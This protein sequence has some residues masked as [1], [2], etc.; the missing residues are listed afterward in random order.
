MAEM[1]VSWVDAVRHASEHIEGLSRDSANH[2]PHGD[3]AA[4]EVAVK[5][6]AQPASAQIGVAL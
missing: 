5:A 4:Q 2:L 6:P 3:G 1:D